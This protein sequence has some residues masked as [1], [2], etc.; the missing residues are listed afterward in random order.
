MNGED[1]SGLI[2]LLPD[3]QIDRSFHCETVNSRDGRV[4]DMVIQ[5]D[6]KIVICGFFSKVNGVDVP[7]IARLN[8]DGS[9]DPSFQTAFMTQEK[10]YQEFSKSRRVAVAKLSKPA[11]T[12]TTALVAKVMPE[13][14]L[15]TVMKLEANGAMIQFTGAANHQYVLQ[16]KD[17][18]AGTDWQTLG[19]NRTTGNGIGIFRDGSAGQNPMRFYRIATP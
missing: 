11:A 8:P 19:T 12:N 14:I 13:T 18:L 6:G 7:H 5:K 15:I 4:M 10:F 9:L 2:R 17:S 1:F 16:A 3:G